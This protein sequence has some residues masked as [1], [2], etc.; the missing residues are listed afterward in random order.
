KTL[1]SGS[2]YVEGKQFKGEIKLWEVAS[3]QEKASLKGHT[4]G[5]FSVAFSPDGK[6]LASASGQQG[7]PGEVKRW[8]VETGQE[9]AALEGHT[10]WVTAVAFSADGKTLASGEVEYDKQSQPLPGEIKLW[11][12][13]TGQ[14]RAALKGHTLGVTSVAFS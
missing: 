1:A 8:E 14:E 10:G 12:V 9:R 7:Q 2:A 3:G 6:T 13:A 4:N 11:D 5:V